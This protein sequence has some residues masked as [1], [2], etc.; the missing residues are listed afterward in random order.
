MLYL[1]NEFMNWF[2]FL[3]ADCDTIILVRTTLYSTS[4]IYK[5]QS[6]AVA[7][8][9]PVAVA[10]RVL[11]NRVCPSYHLTGCFLGIRSLGLSEFWHGARNSWQVKCDRGNFLEKLFLP[12]KL[13][14]WVNIRPKIGFFEFKELFGS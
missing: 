4:L 11:W 8:A 7:L 5:C 2:D 10:E 1:K 13:S 12:P 9:G 6:T 14:K 3:H